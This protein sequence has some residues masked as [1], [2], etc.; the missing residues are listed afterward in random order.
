MTILNAIS[1]RKIL[2]VLSTLEGKDGAQI[3]LE[4]DLLLS[5]MDRVS[6]VIRTSGLP[7][8]KTDIIVNKFD[9]E[10]ESEYFNVLQK[11]VYDAI[12]YY[13]D[14]VT[15]LGAEVNSSIDVI[16]EYLDSAAKLMD[17]QDQELAKLKHLVIKKLNNNS[18]LNETNFSIETLKEDNILVSDVSITPAG[19]VLL[20]VSGNRLLNT[21]I[22]D[23]TFKVI[24]PLAAEKAISF[25]SN[26]NGKSDEKAVIPG[27]F[28]G[29]MYGRLDT[30]TDIRLL[31]AV[32]QITD[33]RND[34]KWECEFVS[35]IPLTTSFQVL[36]SVL[37][38]NQQLLNYIGVDTTAATRAFYHND[39]GARVYLSGNRG[40][41]F[42]EFNGKEL[43]LELTENASNQIEY[44]LDAIVKNG[45]TTHTYNILETLSKHMP[46]DFLLKFPSKRI[47]PVREIEEQTR[48]EEMTTLLL[49]DKYRVAVSL[50]NL[51]TNRNTYKTTGVLETADIPSSSEI[52]GVEIEADTL[53]P[54]AT[55]EWI[56]YSLSFDSGKTWTQIRPAT[57]SATM[58]NTLLPY[59][60]QLA[61]TQEDIGVTVLPSR[62]TK[63]RLKIEMSTNDSAISPIVYNFRVRIKER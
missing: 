34:T 21:S 53:I 5:V 59:R 27:Y 10:I 58:F 50:D 26:V 55:R 47:A 28:E 20:P 42:S 31:S 57:E 37:F 14:I 12:T 15:Q 7:E 38:E 19:H 40:E 9:T 33:G 3:E 56:K 13:R 25:V 63:V 8:L 51:R 1:Q 61:G 44:H 46:D 11:E 62:S 35:A 49:K 43:F 54:D 2:E 41:Y 52:Y 29:K 30:P 39:A 32:N 22:K 60:V 17:R 16:S 45:Y 48:P 4:K 36:I 18:I 6:D 24:S 23:I